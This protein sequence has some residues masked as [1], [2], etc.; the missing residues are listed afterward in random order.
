LLHALRGNKA[1]VTARLDSAFRQDFDDIS[2][3]I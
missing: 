2:P 3:S 1:D